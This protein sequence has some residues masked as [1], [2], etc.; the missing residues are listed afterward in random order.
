MTTPIF[1]EDGSV[2]VEFLREEAKRMAAEKK[3]H[4]ERK[5]IEGHITFLNDTLEDYDWFNSD[6]FIGVVVRV[7]D[8]ESRNYGNKEQKA[9]FDY[10]A[11][12]EYVEY[13]DMSKE[14]IASLMNLVLQAMPTGKAKI[15]F[16][17]DEIEFY[18]A[19]DITPSAIAAR[20]KAEEA[21][22]HKGIKGWWFK[23]LE[24]IFG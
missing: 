13:E 22:L 1:K 9:I 3:A 21:E 14:K 8:L 4:E 23:L 20:K 12:H 17:P 18:H 24:R 19:G 16:D 6:R 5:T 11:H 7:E 10:L 15:A 2:D